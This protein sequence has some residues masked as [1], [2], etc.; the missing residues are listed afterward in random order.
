MREVLSYSRRGNRFTPAP[1]GGVGRPPRGVGDPRRGRRRARLPARRLVRSGGAAD[2]RDRV[3]RGGGDRRARR[4]PSGVRRAG[5]GG[6]AARRRVVAGR[7]RR[8]PGRPTCGS[9]PSTRCGCSRT[10]VDP[11]GLA[12]LWTFFPDPWP[13]TRHHKRRL[14]ERALRRRW[15]PTRLAPGG[16]WRLA[17]DWAG[18]RRADGDG[19]GRRARAH[20]WRR[21][22]MGRSDRS[23]SSSARA[24]TRVAQI[25]DLCYPR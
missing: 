9:A 18:L 2:R 8:R 22:A 21:A 14:V 7:G 20:R 3:G 17:T 10:C 12:E 16:R 23:R 19:A 6:M 13:K 15:P 5:A 1:A 24:S 4:R 25:T 11:D